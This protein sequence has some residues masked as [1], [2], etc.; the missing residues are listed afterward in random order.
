M[1]HE[2]RFGSDQYSYVRRL[3]PSALRLTAPQSEGALFAAVEQLKGKLDQAR[4]AEP[5]SAGIFNFAD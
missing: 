1:Q 4:T 3:K 5:R 2:V